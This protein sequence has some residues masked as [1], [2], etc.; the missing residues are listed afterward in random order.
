M[1]P[2]RSLDIFSTEGE[3]QE[4]TTGAVLPGRRVIHKKF[5]TARGMALGPPTGGVALVVALHSV[6]VSHALWGGR[7]FFERAR[8]S[9]K[10]GAPLPRCYLIRRLY[11]TTAAL[12]S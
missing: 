8:K 10:D 1:Q 3:F 7:S 9:G 12:I 5:T 11:K 6:W 4:C 2:G